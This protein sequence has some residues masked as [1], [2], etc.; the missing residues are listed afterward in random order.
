MQWR[1]QNIRTTKEQPETIAD[2]KFFNHSIHLCS[3]FI[4]EIGVING[5][6]GC[7]EQT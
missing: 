1:P 4:N 2:M 7:F 5:S 3:L 6:T